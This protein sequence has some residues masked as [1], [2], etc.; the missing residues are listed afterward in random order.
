[1]N[2]AL[3]EGAGR[4]R[5]PE[6]P[7]VRTLFELPVGD[8]PRDPSNKGLE[9]FSGRHNVAFAAHLALLL[10][11]A[12]NTQR[13]SDL[14]CLFMITN[15]QCSKPA[16]RRGLAQSSQSNCPVIYSTEQ[17]GYV[18]LDAVRGMSDSQTRI[19]SMISK[20]CCGRFRQRTSSSAHIRSLTLVVACIAA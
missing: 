3:A 12:R 15:Y 5:G 1:M 11:P 13:L 8:L 4:V 2:H 7:E 10:I 16:K 18:N 9:F 6:M 14:L 19:D 20:A 17:G